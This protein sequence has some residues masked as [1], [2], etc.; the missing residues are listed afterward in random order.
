M[1]SN[2]ILPEFCS[3]F[4]CE[5]CDYKTNKKSSY[6]DHLIST[7]HSKAIIGNQNLPK[8]C[9]EHICDNCNK[10]YKDNSGLWRHKKKC[11]QNLHNTNTTNT[12]NTTENKEN[13]EDLIQFLIN[14][15][16]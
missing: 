1:F 6:S 8:F 14:E 3:R 9:S 11:I 4:Y 16:K 5:V 7:K 15:N 2:K 12:T 10:K 13:K